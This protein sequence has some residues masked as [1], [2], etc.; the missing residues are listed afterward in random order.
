M[1]KYCSHCGNEVS[2]EAV[3][4][5]K[6]GCSV[7]NFNASQTVVSRDEVSVGMVILSILIPL[8]GIIYWAVNAKSKPKAA[9]ACGISG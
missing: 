2:E 9:R 4:C 6:C 7:Q 5:V 1:A 3:I 8:V